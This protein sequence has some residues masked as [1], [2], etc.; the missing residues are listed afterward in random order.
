M[1]NLVP[2]IQVSD[3][4]SVS[5][6]SGTAQ[7]FTDSVTY[8]VTAEDHSEQEYIVTVDVLPDGVYLIRK[9]T[10]VVNGVITIDRQSAMEN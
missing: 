7:D 1:D 3:K 9:D 5:P 10:T 8:T 2:V 4:A 6:A